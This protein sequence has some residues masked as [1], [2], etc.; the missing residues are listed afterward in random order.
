MR[1]RQD[2][3]LK[4]Y[5]LYDSIGVD[6]TPVVMDLLDSDIIFDGFYHAA[7]EIIDRENDTPTTSQIEEFP[8]DSMSTHHKR[9]MNIFDFHMRTCNN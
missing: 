1:M 6:T 2:E 9:C 8:N 3:L 5:V 7:M 4:D